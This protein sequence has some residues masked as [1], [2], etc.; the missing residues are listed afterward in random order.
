[1]EAFRRIRR[2]DSLVPTGLHFHLGTGIRDVGIYLKAVREM[3]EFAQAVR[4]ELGIDITQLDLGGGF[5]VPPCVR[6]PNGI[7]D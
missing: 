5:G 1:M 7:G 4:S 6:L 2:H 3:L